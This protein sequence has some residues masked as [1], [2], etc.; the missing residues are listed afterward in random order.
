MLDKRLLR[1]KK[2]VGAQTASLSFLT[3]PGTAEPTR[4]KSQDVLR[5]VSPN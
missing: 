2:P 3:T 1:A 4:A 5:P